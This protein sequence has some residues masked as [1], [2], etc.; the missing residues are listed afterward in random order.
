VIEI[1]EATLDHDRA[2]GNRWVQM[3]F[4]P[5][6]SGI[7]TIRASWVGNADI[8]FTLFQV[9][10]APDL[11]NRLR[12]GSTFGSDVP[13]E[14]TVELSVSEQYYLG[15]WSASGSAYTTVSMIKIEDTNILA[16]D[17]LNY[18][19]ADSS[20]IQGRKFN[21]VSFRP[22][23]SGEVTIELEWQGADF[24]GL[25]V[26]NSSTGVRIAVDDSVNTNA[27]GAN[28]KRITLNLDENTQYDANAWVESGT[29][30]WVLRRIQTVPNPDAAID[31][32]PDNATKPNIVLINTDD[33]RDDTLDRLPAIQTYLSQKGV[34]YTNAI[35]PTPSCC[36]SRA[37]LLSGRYVHNNGQFEQLLENPA[38]FETTINKYLQQAGYFTGTAGKYL[39]WVDRQD[40]APPYW[41]RWTYITGG[42][43]G[44]RMNF[45]GNVID[46]GG[47]TTDIV[48][49]RTKD[50]LRDFEA[51]NDDK[52]WFVYLAPM[53]PHTPEIP[54]YDLR[55][56]PVAPY[57]TDPSYQESDISD[58]PPGFIQFR[59][60]DD[61]T[62]RNRFEQ[63]IR[64]LYSVDREVEQLVKYLED[65]G[66]IDNTIIIFTSDNGYLLGEHQTKGK[67]T[68]WRKSVQVPL[69]ISWPGQIPENVTNTSFVS[70]IDISRTILEAAGVDTS[71]LA[72]DGHN[73]FD[74]TRNQFFMEYF[75]DPRS[76]GGRIGTWASV[77]TPDYQ[78]TEWYNSNDESLVSFREY[79]DMI[80]DPFQLDN[81]LGNDDPNDDPDYSQ[82]S[83]D[84]ELLRNCSGFTCRVP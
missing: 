76:N 24:M 19:I 11:G 34:T 84:L 7:H 6:A 16:S 39:H 56:A 78:Y 13:N 18:G 73:I 22:R 41:D 42:F 2:I 20:N 47:Y 8:R 40:P 63:R 21:K 27:V 30:D 64:T 28:T 68:P 75:I 43:Y 33:Q 4:A 48:F 49:E 37:A 67:F 26:F 3:D 79:Y 32:S 71:A 31:S 60:I 12:I 23:V 83:I 80:N 55:D 46:P 29:A 44:I 25:S 5:L 53:A 54:E 51:R 59:L 15:V 17:V 58:K 10:D 82:L 36:P 70:H 74:E 57:V 77:R 45:D 50:Y 1:G 65:S 66:E 52:P 14:L 72:L 62:A 38:I 35:V 61:A 81:L 69:I 9:I